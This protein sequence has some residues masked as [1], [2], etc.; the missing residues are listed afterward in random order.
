MDNCQTQSSTLIDFLCGEEWVK[1]PLDYVVLHAGARIL[2]PKYHEIVCAFRLHDN[3]TSRWRCLHSIH[4]QIN[5]NLLELSRICLDHRH[6]WSQGLDKL[7]AGF[8]APRLQKE[9][10]ILYDPVQICSS[11][12]GSRLARKEVKLLDYTTGMQ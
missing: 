4:N 11:Y 3:T 5:E 9:Q 2:D 6:I 12:T 8:R 7:N 10:T 1:D